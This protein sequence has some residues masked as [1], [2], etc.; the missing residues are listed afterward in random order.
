LAYSFHK[1]VARRKSPEA[2][3]RRIASMRVEFTGYPFAYIWS[4]VC[5]AENM[6]FK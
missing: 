4:A 3:A 6:L 5:M 2:T 1:L